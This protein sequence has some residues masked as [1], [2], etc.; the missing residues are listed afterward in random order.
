MQDTMHPALHIGR[1]KTHHHVADD[2]GRRLAQAAQ[3]QLLDG[4][5]EAALMHLTGDDEIVLIKR[6][7]ARVR[8]SAQHADRD[9]A[10]RWS[11]ALATSLSH[12]LQHAGPQELL[13][14]GGRAEALQAFV[15]DALHARSARDWAWQRLSLLPATIG[16]SNSP[17]QRHAALL[18]LLADEPDEG[19]P[20]LRGLLHSALWPLLIEALDEGELRGMAQSVLARLAGPGGLHTPGFGAELQPDVKREGAAVGAAGTAADCTAQTELPQWHARTVQ[21]ARTPARTRWALRL[22][23]LLASPSLARR[24]PAAVDAQLRRWTAAPTPGEVAGPGGAYAHGRL[25]AIQ[26]PAPAAAAAEHGTEPSPSVAAALDAINPSSGHTKHGGLLLLA[27]LLP[28][29]GALAL[30]DDPALWPAGA[31]PQAL[32][33]L[34]LSLWPMAPADAAAL[35]FCGLPPTA[36]APEA[37][38]L[39][40]RQDAALQAARQHLLQHLADRLASSLAVASVRSGEALT[41][42]ASAPA[43]ASASASALA[44][45]LAL[46]VPRRARITADPGWIDVHFALRDVSL[47]LRRAALDLDPG[48]LP[49][50]GVVLRVRYE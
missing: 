38:A 10:R 28:A 4:E 49:W 2:A 37:L 23:C 22:G 15:A 6:L 36:S 8:L 46:V 32:H 45:A 47:D 44:L 1:F 43:S 35:A 25:G 24:G 13:R 21:A 9:N 29:S 40:P 31:L 50:L 33:H 39:S 18:R 26:L 20:L 41:D 12:A 42:R 48:F 34:A 27:P 7:Q 3:R 19:V 30:L 5:L 17:E 16:R 11:D 14:F